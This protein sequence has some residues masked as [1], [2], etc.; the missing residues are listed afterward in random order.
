[1]N[2]ASSFIRD[3]DWKLIR[4]YWAG[5]EAKQHYYE[6][7]NLKSDPMEAVNLAGIYPVKV[8]ELDALLEAYLKKTAALTPLPNPDYAG[9]A[10]PPLR[11]ARNHG[12]LSSASCRPKALRLEQTVIH[13]LENGSEIIQLLDEKSV[14]RK[15]VGVLYTGAEWVTVENRSDGSV[16]VEWD[17]AKKK[18]TAELYFGWSGGHTAEEVDDWTLGPYKLELK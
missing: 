13:V 2:A 7:F 17:V 11:Q 6:L 18:G 12:Q 9:T 8:K 1:L 4:F 10:V 3:G 14:K 5:G 16:R 15:T